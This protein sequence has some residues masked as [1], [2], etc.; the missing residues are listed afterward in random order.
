MHASDPRNLLYRLLDPAAAERLKGG[1]SWDGLL[2]ERKLKPTDVDLG[3]RSRAE[4]SDRAL[5]A[6]RNRRGG[7]QWF[8][9]FGR[10]AGHYGERLRVF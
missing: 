4:L 9:V 7:G 8:S 3:S 2:E 6:A 5:A 10:C 1:L